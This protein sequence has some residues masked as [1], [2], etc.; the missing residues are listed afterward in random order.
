MVAALCAKEEL[1]VAQEQERARMAEQLVGPYVHASVCLHLG[2]IP[3]FECVHVY[4]RP[5]N[6][7]RRTAGRWRGT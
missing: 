6:G 2:S 1:R 5:H 3:W 7:N 4:T